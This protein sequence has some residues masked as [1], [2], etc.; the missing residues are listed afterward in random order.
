MNR[1]TGLHACRYLHR[2]GRTARAGAGG[3]GIL[4]LAGFEKYVL[5]SKDF[6]LIEFFGDVA[7]DTGR[8]VNIPVMSAAHESQVDLCMRRV[9]SR[10]KGQ[11]YQ[12][13]LGYYNGLCPKR[14]S[15]S[16]RA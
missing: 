16:W 13:W 12:A 15:W 11:A 8:E 3:Q 10:T 1:V 7:D 4:L 5:R 14:I 6:N 9:D 2:L